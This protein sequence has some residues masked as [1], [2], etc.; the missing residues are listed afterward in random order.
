[1]IQKT[2][3]TC[4]EYLILQI[5]KLHIVSYMDRRMKTVNQLPKNLLELHVHAR[6]Y[7]LIDLTNNVNVGQ[8]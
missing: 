3:M 2:E 4:N 7:I 5:F 6:M 8:D 1:M